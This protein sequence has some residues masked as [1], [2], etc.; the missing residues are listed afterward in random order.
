M[1]I[2]RVALHHG[3]GIRF[4]IVLSEDGSPRNHLHMD[5]LPGAMTSA[6]ALCRAY[7]VETLH[8]VRPAG[9]EREVAIRWSNGDRKDRARFSLSPYSE[10]DPQADDQTL[11]IDL[12]TDLCH[13]MDSSD[14]VC[15]ALNIA[16]DHYEAEV[17]EEDHD[18]DRALMREEA[19]ADEFAWDRVHTSVE[20]DTLG[21]VAS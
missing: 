17:E 9:Q 19:E 20:D 3:P 18:E 12:L 10:E 13:Y 2:D 4:T 5:R 1:S 8:I 14:A 7:G 15:G 21:E 11:V 16:I 6:R